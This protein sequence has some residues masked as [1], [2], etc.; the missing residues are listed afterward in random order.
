MCVYVLEMDK[1]NENIQRE[2]QTHSDVIMLPM[3][4]YYRSLPLKLKL[5]YQWAL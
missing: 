4:D 2:V 1:I 3:V 5:A